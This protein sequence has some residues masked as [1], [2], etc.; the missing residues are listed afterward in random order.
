VHRA[1]STAILSGTETTGPGCDKA[2]DCLK[3]FLAH[4]AR[5][6]TYVTGQPSTWLDY[7]SFHMSG[8]RVA[9]ANPTTLAVPGIRAQAQSQRPN[10]G[11]LATRDGHSA[12]VLVCNYHNDARPAPPT[13]GALTPQ[14][15]T[16]QKTL[17]QHYCPDSQR[18]PAPRFCSLAV[19]SLAWV[20]TKDGQVVLHFTLPHQGVSLL[21]LT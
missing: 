15:S 8:Q 5:G 11:A 14:S 20:S 4:C 10:I 19:P 18:R 17:L 21:H 7:V 13:E 12:A 3:S 16:T 2:T 6:Q 1:L 9:V